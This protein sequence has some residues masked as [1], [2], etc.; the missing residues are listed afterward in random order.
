MQEHSVLSM[1]LGSGPVVQLVLLTLIVLSVSSWAISISKYLQ[2]KKAFSESQEFST[3]FWDIRD[4]TRIEDSCQRLPNSPLVSV[5]KAGYKELLHL[6]K[7]KDLGQDIVLES[8]DTVR[9]ALER[10]AFEEGQKLDQGQTFLATVSSAAPFI[11]LFGTVWGIMTA[12]QGLGTAGTTTLQAVA[13]GI[14]EA[15]VA[16]AIGL[17]AAIPA[18]VAYNFF[19]VSARKLKSQMDR[20]SDEFLVLSEPYI[21]E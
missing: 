9:M 12:F 11:G 13:P 21:P 5:F 6:S 2:L 1:V 15:L 14:S 20:L 16:T 18:S 17:A 8:K 7:R 19:S 4:L 3:I 10:S